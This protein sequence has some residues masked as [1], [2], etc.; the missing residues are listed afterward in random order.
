MIGYPFVNF[1][2]TNK[3]KYGGILIVAI[4]AISIVWVLWERE[5]RTN[6]NYKMQFS[7]VIYKITKVARQNYNVYVTD[8]KKCMLLNDLL[9]RNERYEINIGDS[10]IKLGNNSCFVYKRNSTVI[11]RAC[12]L[13]YGI[14]FDEDSIPCQ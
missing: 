9:R 14:Y 1:K 13:G 2:L 7:G 10:L 4:M 8:G 12:N 3:T 6:A 11:Y 5:R